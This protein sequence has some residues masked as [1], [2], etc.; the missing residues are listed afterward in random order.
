MSK[1]QQKYSLFHRKLLAAYFAVQHIKHL[2]EGK[3]VTVRTD[4]KP[5]ESAFKSRVSTKIDR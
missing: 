2:I 5:L 1:P 4:H 3:I